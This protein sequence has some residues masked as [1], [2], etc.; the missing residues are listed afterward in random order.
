MS[1]DGI[2]KV[3]YSGLGHTAGDIRTAAGVVQ[4]QLDAL[5]AAVDKVTHGWEGEA[6]Q[7]MMAAKAQWD[8]RAQH[9]QSVLEDVSK[10]IE[11]GSTQY[12][13]TDRKAAG[14]FQNLG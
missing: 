13:H 11:H 10:K 7:M 12:Q 5:W 6:H 14:L 8:A 9:I 2:L 4:Q 3:Q 1:G